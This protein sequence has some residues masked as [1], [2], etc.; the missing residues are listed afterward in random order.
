MKD[1]TRENTF[2]CGGRV[3]SPSHRLPRW[4]KRGK[5][6]KR[7]HDATDAALAREHFE[8]ALP[9]ESRVWLTHD[10]GNAFAFNRVA[11]APCDARDTPDIG[12]PVRRNAGVDPLIDGGSHVVRG[13]S[14]RRV[15]AKTV[16]EFF[17]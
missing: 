2:R 8:D 12:D 10:G 11:K 3:R 13:R 1:R 17:A 15:L 16:L 5:A 9:T 14:G 7:V 4:N 6:I